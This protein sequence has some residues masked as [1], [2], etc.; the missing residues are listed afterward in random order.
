VN[1]RKACTRI[2]CNI[3]MSAFGTNPTCWGGLTM[4][5]DQ[6]DRKGWPTVKVT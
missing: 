2:V 6:V 1:C 4:S 3:A 5:V